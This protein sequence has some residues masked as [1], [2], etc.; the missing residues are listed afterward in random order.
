M[1]FRS[2]LSCMSVNSLFKTQAV[3]YEEVSKEI[4][5]LRSAEDEARMRVV[6]SVLERNKKFDKVYFRFCM[7]QCLVQD[8]ADQEKDEKKA[9]ELVLASGFSI[10]KSSFYVKPLISVKQDMISGNLIL[11]V[12]SSGIRTIYEWQV[13]FDNGENYMSLPPTLSSRNVICNASPFKIH[14][15]RFRSLTKFK[16]SEWSTTVKIFPNDITPPYVAP[17]TKK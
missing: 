14:L 11:R 1:L 4:K 7:L 2:I 3:S 12:K 5:E 15:F 6:G 9:K 8:L 16:V 13:S 17:K 10:K